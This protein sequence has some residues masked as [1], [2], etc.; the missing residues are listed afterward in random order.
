MFKKTKYKILRKAITPELA[1]FCYAYFL[2][3]RKVSRFFFDIKW[4]SPF[5]TEWGAWNDEPWHG[6]PCFPFFYFVP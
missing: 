5:A 1:K 6:P 4:V 3:K 2:N